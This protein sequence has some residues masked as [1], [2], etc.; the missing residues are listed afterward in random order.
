[1]TVLHVIKLLFLM[2]SV[3][4]FFKISLIVYRHVKCVFACVNTVSEFFCLAGCS[5]V[6]SLCFSCRPMCICW[7]VLCIYD[8]HL[9][10]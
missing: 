8:C 4:F 3:E 10:K 2:L 6:F 9:A 1:M 7:C 5:Y